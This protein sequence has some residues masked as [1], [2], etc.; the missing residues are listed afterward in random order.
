MIVY[1]LKVMVYDLVLIR[2]SKVNFLVILIVK[3]EDK[4]TGPRLAMISQIT[5]QVLVGRLYIYYRNKDIRL[6]GSTLVLLKTQSYA[7]QVPP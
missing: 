5:K 1:D 6:P 2:H 3:Q 4:G 7:G